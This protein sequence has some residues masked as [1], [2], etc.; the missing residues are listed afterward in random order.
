V[1]SGDIDYALNRVREGLQK[2]L[3]HFQEGVRPELLNAGRVFVGPFD[4][5]PDYCCEQWFVRCCMK[6]WL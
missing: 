4:H 6:F 2:N 1:V 3:N 5:W